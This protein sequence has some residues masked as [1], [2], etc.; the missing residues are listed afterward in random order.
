MQ[1]SMT[2]VGGLGPSDTKMWQLVH[3]HSIAALTFL[4][5]DIL[6]TLA[7]EIAFI[8]TKPRFS[9]IKW[10]FFFARYFALAVALSNQFIMWHI[11]ASY[12]NVAHICRP[13]FAF[14]ASVELLLGCVLDVI[15]M[16][17][18]HALYNRD[19]RITVVLIALFVGQ[20][21]T[22]VFCAIF[23][24]ASFNFNPVCLPNNTPRSFL[25]IVIQGLVTQVILLG[26]ALF[27][28]INISHPARTRS[29]IVT[30]MLRDDLIVF[31]A[32]VGLFL[33]LMVTILMHNG[34][35]RGV[36][37]WFMSI[38][39]SASCKAI[40]NMQHLS[41]KGGNNNAS[42][43]TVVRFTTDIDPEAFCMN[44][45]PISPTP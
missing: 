7:D 44:S 5:W 45:M 3:Y 30:I 2:E 11:T 43:P 15:L 23:M 20:V 41:V 12:P 35:Y 31:F 13:W 1:N 29:S 34:A 24:V 22:I 39:G 4:V 18:V 10:L 6:T 14:Q 27:Q 36:H 38:L 21:L 37:F 28:Y 42:G 8:W 9:P 25:P 16:I 32:V 33:F 40:I 26:L 17:R 19:K